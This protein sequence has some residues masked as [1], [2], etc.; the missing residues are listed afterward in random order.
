MMQ[1]E[2]EGKKIL[3]GIEVTNKSITSKRGS[4]WILGAFFKTVVLVYV[5][6][7]RLKCS[8]VHDGGSTVLSCGCRLLSTA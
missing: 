6:A 4:L 5:N 2:T 8:A 1:Q 7:A 3:S